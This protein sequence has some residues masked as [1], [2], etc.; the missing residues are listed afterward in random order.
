[1]RKLS[2]FNFITLNGYYKG[3]ND[4]TSWH[5]HTEE[6]A[7]YSTQ[8]MKLGNTLIFGR[9]TYEMMY[10]FWPSPMA[11]EYFP[12]VAKGMNA[13]EK[14]VISTSIK[15][16]EWN[17][18]SKL[19]SPLIEGITALK[20]TA[21]NNLT[22]LGSGSIISQLAEQNL[23]DEFQFMIDPLTIPAGTEIF[24]GCKNKIDLELISTKVF[25][26]GAILATYQPKK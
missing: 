19:S 24:H 6:A 18:T 7:A 22:I 20:K 13:A 4:D 1:M 15:A 9:K 3:I 14:I 11:A 16:P 26:S 2:A 8:Q 12:E 10:S 17:N 25:K 23:I 21:G 5:Q